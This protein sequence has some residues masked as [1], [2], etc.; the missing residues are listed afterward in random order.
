MPELKNIGLNTYAINIGETL[1]AKIT[2]VAVKN[3]GGSSMLVYTTEGDFCAFRMNGGNLGC[4]VY[5]RGE[6][7]HME[8][9]T[10][11]A[12]IGTDDDFRRDQEETHGKKAADRIMEELT[13]RRR[14]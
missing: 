3:M 8:T 4:P 6:D 1:V 14:K 13:E 7:S 10:L 11:W 12:M 2:G 5:W 9:V